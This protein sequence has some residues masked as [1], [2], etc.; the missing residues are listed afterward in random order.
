MSSKL[1]QMCAAS[2]GWCH[3]VNA[4]EIKSGW[5]FGWQVKLCDPVNTCHSVAL[6]DCLGRKNALYEYLI[7]Y[8]LYVTFI[9][10]NILAKCQSRRFST[11]ILLCLRKGAI[12]VESKQLTT[13]LLTSS[14]ADDFQ[15]TVT[16]DSADLY[17]VVTKHT[18]HATIQWRNWG[19]R[20]QGQHR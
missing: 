4:Y 3:L 6:R 18:I 12:Y 2:F 8:L 14:N 10:S 5:S 13:I 9:T 20:R 15:N 17:H 11:S 16:S 19:F 7:L 1:Y